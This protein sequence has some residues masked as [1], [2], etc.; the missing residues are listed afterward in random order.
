MFCRECSWSLPAWVS[1]WIHL[2]ILAPACG[3]FLLS[4]QGETKYLLSNSR[5]FRWV[6]VCNL[7]PGYASDCPR[8]AQTLPGPVQTCCR[9]TAT[10]FTFANT[11]VDLCVW[12]ETFRP[13]AGLEI[14]V[15]CGHSIEKFPHRRRLLFTSPSWEEIPGPA[16]RPPPLIQHRNNITDV[17]GG[18]RCLRDEFINPDKPSL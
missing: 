12:D 6:T 7:E 14:P 15:F 11:L 13:R 8:S 18:A 17:D 9:A 4:V 1:L 3:H 2:L 10:C 16:G 5:G